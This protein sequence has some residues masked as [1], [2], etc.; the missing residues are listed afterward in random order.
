MRVANI[1]NPIVRLNY[2]QIGFFLHLG[3][4]YPPERMRI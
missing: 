3:R 2:L 4:K 1:Q